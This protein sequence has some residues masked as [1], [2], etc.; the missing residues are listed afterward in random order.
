MAT[1]EKEKLI[2]NFDNLAEVQQWRTIDDLVMGGVS[3]SIIKA[4]SQGT[5]LFTGTVSLET[6]G[7]FSSVSSRS[8]FYLS[9]FI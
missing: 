8:K 7:G 2:F 6:F 3:Q 5:V 4:G 9:F 1:E